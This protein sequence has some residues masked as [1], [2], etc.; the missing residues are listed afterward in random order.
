MEGTVEQEVDV[1]KLRSLARTRN[2]EELDGVGEL[3]ELVGLGNIGAVYQVARESGELV[4]AKVMHEHIKENDSLRDRFLREATI[5]DQTDHPSSIEV[6]GTGET[7]EGEAYFVMEYLEGRPLQQL[8]EKLEEFP[9]D[10]SLRIAEQALDCLEAYHRAEVLHRD[11]K[12]A[13]LFVTREGVV[14]LLDFGLARFRTE[15]RDP[16]K[17]GTAMGT[18]A[19]MAPE[20]AL[21]H[22]NEIDER[23]DVF[24]MGAVLYKLLSGRTIHDIDSVQAT[25]V[26]AATSRP[27]PLETHAPDV[28]APVAKLVDRAVAR[29][30]EERFQSAADMRD[31]I[32]EALELIRD[33]EA[34]SLDAEGSVAELTDEELSDDGVD[35]PMDDDLR[36]DDFLPDD[37]ALSGAASAEE[38]ELEPADGGTPIGREP[39]ETTPDE[40]LA[41]GMDRE[42]GPT[43]SEESELSEASDDTSSAEAPDED[44]SIVMEADELEG[45]LGESDGDGP[46][47]NKPASEPEPPDLTTELKRMLE[48]VRSDK[49]DGDFLRAMNDALDT[50]EEAREGGVRRVA[51]QIQ[52][53]GFEA[54]GGEYHA[55]DGDLSDLPQTLQAEGF[56][57][58][59]VETSVD[60]DELSMFVQWLGTD[61]RS[62]LPGEDDLATRFRELQLSSIGAG[63]YP[64]FRWDD[65]GD[66]SFRGP[67]SNAR[68]ASRATSYLH[69]TEG[70]WQGLETL[71]DEAGSAGRSS[72]LPAPTASISSRLVSHADD[73]LR[74]PK[75]VLSLDVASALDDAL[76]S[77]QHGGS[78]QLG[79][80]FAEIWNEEPSNLER[81]TRAVRELFCSYV[82][83]ELGRQLVEI[84][85]T[86]CRKI[87][88]TGDRRDFVAA[89]IDDI[90]V[91]RLI[92]VVDQTIDE[93]DADRDKLVGL[94]ARIA[95]EF[96]ASRRAEIIATYEFGDDFTR[97]ILGPY[98]ERFEVSEGG[99]IE[100]TE[101]ADPTASP[102]GDRGADE[103]LGSGESV[104]WRRAFAGEIYRLFR[105]AVFEEADAQTRKKFTGEFLSRVDK[106]FQLAPDRLS[107]LFTDNRILVDGLPLKGS[108]SSYEAL[109]SV[110]DFLDRFDCNK[111]SL[112]QGVDE[113]DIGALLEVLGRMNEGASDLEAPF[114]VGSRVRI[115]QTDP[116]VRYGMVEPLVGEEPIE[117]RMGEYYAACV[118]TLGQF[119]RTS[120]EERTEWL[121]P[122]KRMNQTW[123]RLSGRSRASTLALTGFDETGADPA[124]IVLDSTLL[125]ILMA[126]RLTGRTDALRRIGFAALAVDFVGPNRDDRMTQW[127]SAAQGAA[128]I[129]ANA[130]TD[131]DT[132]RRA[133]TAF[134]IG[135][136]FDNDPSELP[137]D[138][139]TPKVETLLVG[140]AREFTAM[141]AGL[142]AEDDA[143]P[144]EIVESISKSKNLRVERYLL[145]L[146]VDTLGLFTRGM[147]VELSSRWRGVVLSSNDHITAF[148]LPRVRLMR[149]PDGERVSP[150]EVDLAKELDGGEYGYVVRRLED[151]DSQEASNIEDSMTDSMR[152]S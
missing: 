109:R 79:A 26:Q 134:E 90:E 100:T 78:H 62:A 33:G 44:P 130:R 37:S 72:G 127:N 69:G 141:A 105:V 102:E 84:L 67:A 20:Q 149:N 87:D 128:A 53:H 61:T 65:R 150:V 75:G 139:T 118:T 93:E 47:D 114:E 25:L 70:S 23:T 55:F 21:G 77:K 64:V 107:I 39:G 135:R 122:L 32:R 66:A 116:A 19:Y 97:H 71:A 145:H 106:L 143:T 151:I 85:G 2:G 113:E 51:W 120:P 137:Y 35:Q 68:L 76:G 50:L 16:T 123:V 9:V 124:A 63:I 140:I 30:R 1:E 14:K 89:A 86:A 59:M 49:A 38:P 117:T 131:D 11:L 54:D 46:P 3:A 58:L 29:S 45:L 119:A 74:T 112:E 91:E 8:A 5:L 125:S 43:L 83:R 80:L 99:N 95:E 52:P 121:A 15:D 48:A 126:R 31:A 136:R 7:E 98:R 146:L 103:G 147:P 73:F 22:Q 110:G 27:D 132:L 129:L 56:H 94:L 88:E 12:P 101:A 60:E 4:A 24:G 36:S 41:R 40:A 104:D 17:A 18:P 96:P 13:N 10:R 28:P 115:E 82:D 42:T 144:R 34:E 108:A 148:H 142:G 111:L 138:D 6:Y 152:R 57:R 133:V 92:E 81:P